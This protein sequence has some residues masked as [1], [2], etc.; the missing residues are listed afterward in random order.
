MSVSRSDLAK[1]D[2]VQRRA[3]RRTAWIFTVVARLERAVAT[4]VPI[5]ITTGCEFASGYAV[6]RIVEISVVA[7]LHACPH[8]TVATTSELTV[9]QASVGIVL[10]PVVAVFAIIRDTIAAEWVAIAIAIAVAVAI[11]VAIAGALRRLGQIWIG[12][13]AH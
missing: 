1:P 5:A 13:A 6:V 8:M 3:V 12:I 10:I 11:A 4:V 7:L 9:A 2:R